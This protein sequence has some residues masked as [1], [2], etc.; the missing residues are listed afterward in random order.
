MSLSLPLALSAACEV[1]NV[2]MLRPKDN[3]IK[4]KQYNSIKQTN[5]YTNDDYNILETKTRKGHRREAAATT[6]N[7][8]INNKY[9]NSCI[10]IIVSIAIGVISI[11]CLSLLSL[12]LLLL[13][14]FRV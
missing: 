4:L 11:I 13:L 9:A 8:T 2:K 5:N 1:T 10:I 12:V 14:G 3:S 7:N 6:T